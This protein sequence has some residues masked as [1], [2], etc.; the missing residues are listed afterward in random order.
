MIITKETQITT[1]GLSRDS[2]KTVTIIRVLFIPVYKS[3][4]VIKPE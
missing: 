4:R 3:T 2:Q 1:S